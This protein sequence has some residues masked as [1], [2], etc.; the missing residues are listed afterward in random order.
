MPSKI[1]YCTK[2]FQGPL[3]AWYDCQGCC[4]GAKEEALKHVRWLYKNQI[5]KLLKST[6][7]PIQ[8][9]SAGQSVPGTSSP[10]SHPG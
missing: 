7:S 1:M 2:H 3:D 9:P 10:R 6:P 4:Q 8:P 5:K